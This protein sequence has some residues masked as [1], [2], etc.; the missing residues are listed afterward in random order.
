M[1]VHFALEPFEKSIFLAGPTPRDANT[2]SWR[3]GAIEMLD[4]ELGFDGE[5]LVPENASYT[6]QATYDAQ[7]HWEWEALNRATVVVVWVPRDLAVFPA[8]TTN[9]EFGY[10]I[11]TGKV[12]LGYPHDAPKMT[13]LHKLAERHHAPVVHSLTATLEEAVRRA[14]GKF[15]GA[16]S[17]AAKLRG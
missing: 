15:G 5:V 14:N 9:V 16:V 12:V 4:K 17:S 11:A 6:S 2:P 8:F 3:P 13:Y 10:M 7:I 1:K